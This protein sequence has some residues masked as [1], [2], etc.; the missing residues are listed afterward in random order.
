MLE[1][2]FTEENMMADR[3]LSVVLNELIGVLTTKQQYL[4]QPTLLELQALIGEPL[5][6]SPVPEADRDVW[7]LLQAAEQKKLELKAERQDEQLIYRV[8]FGVSQRTFLMSLEEAAFVV[9]LA[10]HSLRIYLYRHAKDHDGQQYYNAE[11]FERGPML[12]HT[13]EQQQWI[14]DH[15]SFKGYP[16][17]VTITKHGKGVLNGRKEI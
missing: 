5:N 7:T 1:F 15:N 17:F 13:P 6:F 8:E 12:K 9:G 10:P 2:N 3:A 14:K 11:V 16:E 4:Y